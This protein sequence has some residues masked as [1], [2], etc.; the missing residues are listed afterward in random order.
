MRLSVIVKFLHIDKLIGA[1]GN[2]DG[3]RLCAPADLPR[4]MHSELPNSV[5]ASFLVRL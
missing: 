5:I 2:S 1:H 3:T 4:G